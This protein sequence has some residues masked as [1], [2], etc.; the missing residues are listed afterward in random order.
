MF[1]LRNNNDGCGGG[2]QRLICC[3]IAAVLSFCPLQALKQP[4][5]SSLFTK[6]LHNNSSL[7]AIKSDNHNNSSTTGTNL[8]VAPVVVENNSSSNNS[9]T[10]WVTE[11]NIDSHS[12]SN[13]ANFSTGRY[14]ATVE[15]YGVT[16]TSRTSA[17]AHNWYVNYCM[18]K[19]LIFLF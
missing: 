11:T 19:Y 8:L 5:A 18:I 7:L 15:D 10:I 4:E 14:L 12:W 16:W 1:Y 9:D 13:I 3:W 17:G 2:R 6:N